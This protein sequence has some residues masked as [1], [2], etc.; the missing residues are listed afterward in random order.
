MRSSDWSSDVCSSDLN[1][2]HGLN[3]DLGFTD[4]DRVENIRR[5]GEVAKLMADAGLIVLCGFISPF[6]AERRMVREMMKEDEFQGVFVDTPRAQA[7]K[8]NEKGRFKK[9]RRGEF[10][11]LTCIDHP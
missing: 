9:A 4:V 10:A 1:V 2:R 11:K 8:S 7:E 6:R 3:K 5:V